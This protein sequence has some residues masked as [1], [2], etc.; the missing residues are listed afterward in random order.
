F[1][2]EIPDELRGLAKEA[3]VEDT[4]PTFEEQELAEVGHYTGGVSWI[5][6]PTVE[7][8]DFSTRSVEDIFELL[9]TSVLSETEESRLIATKLER[10][11]LEYCSQ[12]P[13]KALEIG[14]MIMKEPI[15]PR[16]IKSLLTGFRQAALASKTI[17]W[18]GILQFGAWTIRRASEKADE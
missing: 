5:A 13:D 12:L 11:F 8:E 6:E 9:K 10:S 15:A 2:G 14:K 18:D 4:K 17:D 1:R 3:G 7:S 16:L